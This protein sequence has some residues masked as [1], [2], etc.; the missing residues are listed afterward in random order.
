[1]AIAPGSEFSRQ[2]N[3]KV[4]SSDIS[5]PS[6]PVRRPPAAK[7]PRQTSSANTASPSIPPLPVDD[8]KELVRF[9]KLLSDETR[10]RILH[11]LTQQTELHVRALCELL[12]QSQPAVSHHLALLRS[13]GLI[14]PRRDG[15]HNFYRLC[16]TRRTELSTVFLEHTAY[17][18]H[19]AAADS[20]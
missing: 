13:G 1:M 8:A 16:P 7:A 15:K 12:G 17:L 11:Y 14:E 5:E 18:E 10:L 19:A 4:P 2:S 20:K 3:V 6:S 9:F